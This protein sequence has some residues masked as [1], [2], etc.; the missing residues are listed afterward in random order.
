MQFQ[1]LGFA[2]VAIGLSPRDGELSDDCATADSI[3][4]DSGK[5]EMVQAR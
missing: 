2:T 3:L 4:I 1:H 5:L